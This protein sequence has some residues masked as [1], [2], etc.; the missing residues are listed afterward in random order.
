MLV[1]Q[2]PSVVGAIVLSAEAAMLKCVNM[3]N[4]YVGSR[5]EFVELI[6]VPDVWVSEKLL[7]EEGGQCGGGHNASWSDISKAFMHSW[8][9]G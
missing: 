5:F 9:T 4:V 6:C 1:V 8:M 2:E 3:G 7:K